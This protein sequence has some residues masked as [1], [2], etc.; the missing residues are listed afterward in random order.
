MKKHHQNMYRKQKK[1]AAFRPAVWLVPR[2]FA[3]RAQRKIA[4]ESVPIDSMSMSV[5]RPILLI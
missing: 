2:Y 1:T 5:R 4:V 3:V